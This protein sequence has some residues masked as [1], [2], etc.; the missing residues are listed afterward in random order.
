MASD[1]GNRP[2]QRTKKHHC[3]TTKRNAEQSFDLTVICEFLSWTAS[4]SCTRHSSR[5]SPIW[6]SRVPC[7]FW[8]VFRDGPSCMTVRITLCHDF[9]GSMIHERLRCDLTV[10]PITCINCGYWKSLIAQT[11]ANKRWKA[12]CPATVSLP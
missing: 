8:C 4:L 11:I 7:A 9:R 6:K 2:L 5:A 1:T 10:T 12:R 3:A